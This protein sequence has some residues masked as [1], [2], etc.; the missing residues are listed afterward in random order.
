MAKDA[1]IVKV[2][3]EMRGLTQL[4]LATRV[5]VSEPTIRRMEAGDPNVKNT[6]KARV[7]EELRLEFNWA[8]NQI[9]PPNN[10]PASAF[11][12]EENEA[13]EDAQRA[14]RLLGE[15]SSLV[16]KGVLTS[17]RVMGTVRRAAASQSDAARKKASRKRTS[18]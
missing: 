4:E 13:P 18:Q 12:E 8:T 10:I 6:T 2:V 5:G 7:A 16:A 17:G 3:R 9:L 11:T 14:K 15:L 1:R